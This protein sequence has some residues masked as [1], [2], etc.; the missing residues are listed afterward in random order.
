MEMEMAHERRHN[1]KRQEGMAPW[2]KNGQ[3]DEGC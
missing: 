3:I 2:G 1:E